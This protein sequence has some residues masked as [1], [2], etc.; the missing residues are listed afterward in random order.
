ME[1]WTSE[2]RGTVE[3]T[4]FSN[5]PRNYIGKPQLD[6]L[7]QLVAQWRDPAIRAV[8]IQSRT[9]E[10]T[11]FTQYSVEELYGMA[12][13]PALSRYA[14]AVVRGY[15]AMFDDMM[16]LPKVVIAAMN[17]DALGGGFEL[18][19]A[20]DLRIGQHGDFRYG[21]PEVR[22]GVMPGA[23]GTQRIS[24]LVGLA[25]ALDWVLRGRI[26]PP[27]AALQLG[28]VHELVD[29][30]PARALELAEEIALLPPMSVAN[31]KRALYLGADTNLQAAYEIENMNWTEVMQSDD[32]KVALS[33]FVAVDPD[34]RRDW[35]ES[36]NSKNYPAY[37][38][39]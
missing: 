36:A 4:T 18:T 39:H 27:E 29:D 22:A 12:S 5:P 15:K 26:V 34:E 16:A 37:S 10:N 17:G 32:A 20:C 3:I 21:N 19:L 13:D 31:A 30:A 7:A 9:G 14:G 33:T 35:F 11:G 25:R 23:G 24:R 2:R 1:F 6:E 38:G 28:L 8:V